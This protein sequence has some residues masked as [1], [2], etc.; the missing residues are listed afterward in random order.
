LIGEKIP[1]TLLTNHTI[2]IRTMIVPTKPK[3][4]IRSPP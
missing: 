2:S 3:P 1:Q 4:N